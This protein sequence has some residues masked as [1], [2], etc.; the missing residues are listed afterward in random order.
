[1]MRHKE[2][3]QKFMKRESH[4]LFAQETKFSYE[5]W[6]LR[7]GISTHTSEK[8]NLHSSNSP[9]L[10][11]SFI[12]RKQVQHVQTVSNNFA[13]LARLKQ[14]VFNNERIQEC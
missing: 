2:P 7:K 9:L 6:N 10:T 12:Q 4:L 14:P 5:F 13:R 11:V 3:Y 8:V 1:M